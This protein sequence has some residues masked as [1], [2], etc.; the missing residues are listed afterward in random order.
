M[1][2]KVNLITD[3]ITGKTR[4]RFYEKDRIQKKLSKTSKKLNVPVEVITSV[5]QIK[6]NS[7]RSA[8]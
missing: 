2:D 4:F 1:S 3:S 5:D 6:D 8:I 7:V